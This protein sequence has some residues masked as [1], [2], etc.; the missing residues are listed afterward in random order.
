MLKL[1]KP[2]VLNTV[3]KGSQSKYNNYFRIKINY[4]QYIEDKRF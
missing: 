2:I 3:I 4:G 1:T